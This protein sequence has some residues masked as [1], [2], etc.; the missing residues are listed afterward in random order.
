MSLYNIFSKRQKAVRGD[1]PDVFTYDTIPREL[2]VQV[3]HIWRDTIGNQQSYDTYGDV[4]MTYRFI[5]ETLCREYGLFELPGRRDNP[6]ENYRLELENFLL[7]ETD[8]ERAL[9]AIELAFE[10][11]DTTIR[12][13]DYTGRSGPN[14]NQI[15]DDAINELNSRFREHGIGYEFNGEIIRVDSQML[16]AEAVKHALTLLRESAYKGAEA[17]FLT[18]HEHYRHGRQKEALTESL[19]AMESVM[20]SICAKRDWTVDPHAPA[21]TL[22]QTLFDN[23]L[24]QKFWTSH[25]SALQSTLE[26]GVPTA[27]NKLGGHGQ[28][29]EVKVVPDYLVGYVLHLTA[30]A[31]LFLVNAE[32]ELP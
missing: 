29:S 11:V 22:L 15:A 27:R 25:F 4:K 2:K 32:K 24:I 16:H 23:G 8:H 31:I 12:R 26:A 18:A 13:P 6:Y 7:Q 21:R 19:K 9:D 14:C 17:E 1:A 5:V 30:S 10:H 3:I 28:G 20:K